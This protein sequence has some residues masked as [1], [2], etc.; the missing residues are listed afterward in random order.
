MAHPETK[1]CIPCSG[2]AKALTD[3]ELKEHL[4]DIPGW[5]V[6]SENGI[7]R[8]VKSFTFNDFVAAMEFTRRI[9]ELAESEGHH[10]AILT[11]WGRVTVSWWTHAIRGLHMNDIVMAARTDRL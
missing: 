5:S 11:E 4:K 9:G 10:P 7:P 6:V 8:L 3:E 2:A 1:H